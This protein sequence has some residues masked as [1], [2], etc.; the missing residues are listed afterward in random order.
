MTV[1][2]FLVCVLAI[3]IVVRF[4]THRPDRVDRH[5]QEA[6][7]DP[8]DTSEVLPE[9]RHLVDA[10]IGQAY[11]DIYDYR[12]LQRLPGETSYRKEN[13]P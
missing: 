13:S 1:A 9:Y 3:R 12:R 5:A 10:W 4:H 6:A 2:L 7:L 8:A 11:E